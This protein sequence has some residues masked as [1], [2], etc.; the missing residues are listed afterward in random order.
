MKINQPE[1]NNAYDA[2]KMVRKIILK[3]F[4]KTDLEVM[5]DEW[6]EL[7][8]MLLATEQGML[9]ATNIKRELGG[10]YEN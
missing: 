2:F 8:N 5:P 6:L 7:C 3:H 1:A 9:D 10:R 4:N